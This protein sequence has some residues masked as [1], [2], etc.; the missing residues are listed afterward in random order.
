[1]LLETSELTA[2]D[3]AALAAAAKIACRYTSL[4]VLISNLIRLDAGTA[5]DISLC[6]AAF[7]QE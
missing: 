7:A 4:L 1:M 5:L 3:G 2:V 6:I